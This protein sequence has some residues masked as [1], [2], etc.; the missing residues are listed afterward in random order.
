MDAPVEPGLPPKPEPVY[1]T[2]HQR[3]ILWTALSA[4][5][6]SM[7][8]A[9]A[10]L[11][12][13][14]FISF[15]GWCYPILLPIG[16]AVIIALVLEPL[17]NQVQKRG[18]NRSNATLVVCILSIVAFLLFWA[19]LVSMTGSFV[20]TLPKTLNEGVNKLQATLASQVDLPPADHSVTAATGTT[21]TPPSTNAPG[22]VP[23]EV[24]L[25]ASSPE[26]NQ[27]GLCLW[28]KAGTG[29]TA[30]TKGRVSR[31]VDQSPGKHDA[32]Q[33]N[34]DRQ[35]TVL[36]NGLNGQPVIEYHDDT[37]LST[38]D[39]VTSGQDY[40]V[41][42]VSTL[43]KASGP[44]YNGEPGKS[45]WGFDRAGDLPTYA[46]DVAGSGQQT[47]GTVEHA[48]K[49]QLLAVTREATTTRFFAYGKLVGKDTLP[50]IAP[51]GVTSIGAT[52]DGKSFAG[53]I[54]EI[55]VYNRAISN[56]ER[57][58]I[59]LYLADKYDLPL[60]GTASG[61]ERKLGNH[62]SEIQ[63]WLTANIP[64]IQDAIQKNLA[65]L[66][67]SI[68]GP[69]GQAFGFVLGFGFV[70]IYVYYF[71]A[72]QEQI[73]RHWHDYIPLRRSPLRDEVISVLT[74]INTSLVSYFRGQ[75]IVAG[76]NGVLTWI[77]LWII[78][79][80]YSLPL[81]IITGALSIVPFLGIIASI[82][83]ALLLGF[84]SAKGDPT[85][86]WLSPLLVVGVF[87]LVQMCESMF[88]T[89]RVQSHSTGLHP[90]AIILGILFW[91]LLLPGLLGPIVAVPLT[92]ALV[93]LMRR[94]VWKE[95]LEAEEPVSP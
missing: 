79:V 77:G 28:L 46:I 15:L 63:K 53:K 38:H 17:V 19:P 49:V 74:E 78:G 12:F 45:G 84:L 33:A 36:T 67:Y 2:A 6:V 76:C 7:L 87:T 37:W 25:T 39:V 95:S 32:Y 1:P 41:L 5:A 81:G 42:V 57:Q 4:L 14:G 52:R 58:Q 47:F 62:Q 66:A 90:L 69:V 43:G 51:A 83:P 30:D 64:A 40:S 59:E 89:P 73:S 48:D 65:A 71:L 9:V 75:I 16:L 13:F 18:L 82:I 61:K 31:W 70:P 44:L 3:F 22:T 88:I 91:S 94:Y 86:Q 8:L 85:W 72:D 80:P 20:T 29:V 60:S 55:I 21:E 93:V 34:T 26:N 54:A 35:P 68:L 56:L 11:V 10:A 50:M 92:C 24:A 23:V 27:L